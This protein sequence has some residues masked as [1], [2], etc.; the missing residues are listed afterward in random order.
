MT[1]FDR[2]QI[3]AKNVAIFCCQNRN[4]VNPERD[5]HSY[6]QILNLTSGQTIQQIH[7]FKTRMHARPF[8]G[9][10]WVSWYQKGKTMIAYCNNS[11]VLIKKCKHCPSNAIL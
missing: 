8:N 10:I 5:S 9:T 1:A 3:Y 4:S 2:N 6:A 7:S 11:I